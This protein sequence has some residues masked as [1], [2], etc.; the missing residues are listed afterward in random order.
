MYDVLI[1]G[2]GGAGLT[3]SMLLSQLGVD[4]MLVSSLPTTSALPKAHV[5]NQ[6]TMEIFA[7]LGIADAVYERGTPPEQMRYSGWYAG[8]A[9][10]DDGSDDSPDDDHGRRLGLVE[11]WGCGGRS[12]E[13]ASASPHLSTNLPQIRLEPILKARAEELAP[14][15]IRFNH[16]LTA[17]VQDSEGVTATI[18]DRG[19][20]QASEIRSRYLLAC[21]GGR[22]VGKLLGVEMEGLRDLARVATVH[23][24]ADLSARAQDPEVLIRWLVL[25]HTGAGA[26]M[27]PMGPDRWGPDSEEWV[28]HLNY[29]ADDHRGLDD[30]QVIADLR[31]ALGLPDHPIDVHL[32]TRWSIEGVVADRFRD[33]RVFLLGDA[34]HRH[35]PTGGLGLNSAIQDAANL[36]WKLAAVLR[37]DADPRLLDT[38]EP[39]RKPVTTRNVQRSIENALNHLVTAEMTGIS[40][41]NS[42][43][44]NWQSLR[45]LWSGLD[46]DAEFAAT[47]RRAIASQSME[48]DEHNIEYGY[49]YESAA[50]VPDGT[51]EPANPDP[52]RIYQPV[53]RPGH[54]LPHAWLEDRLGRRLSVHDLVHPGRFLLIAAEDAHDWCTAATKLADTWPLDA[55]RIG[56]LDGDY[57]DPRSTW[58]RHRGHPGQGAILVRPDRFV[59]WRTQS[60]DHATERLAEVLRAILG[61]AGTE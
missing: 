48:F 6:H 41:E 15:G 2:G 35:P 10:P 1:V 36:A 61:V 53:A 3:A 50:I 39:E 17:L 40:P 60:S 19:T 20:G 51:P 28:V 22:T 8:L 24:S 9:G 38:Y 37:G 46:E 56:H 14:R 23:F 4:S 32:V 43:Q 12:P 47:I 29:A 57:L 45:R 11:S 25:P 55:V 27:V 54:P 34:A 31:T 18:V 33:G 26:T 58:T 42:P 5:L 30:G 16:E 52:V 49:T 59:A 44:A 13:W 21:D 7:G